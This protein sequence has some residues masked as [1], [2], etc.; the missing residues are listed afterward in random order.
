[1]EPFSTLVKNST[2]WDLH[3]GSRAV[4][5][6]KPSKLHLRIK[7]ESLERVLKAL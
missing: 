1:M 5:I 6:C 7:L 4:A 2:N 3:G